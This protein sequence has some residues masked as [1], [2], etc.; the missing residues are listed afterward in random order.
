M[1]KYLIMMITAIAV[2]VSCGQENLLQENETVQQTPITFNLIANHP[3]ATKAVKTGWEAGDAIF[4]FFDNVAAPKHL[5]MAYDGSAWACAEYDG[6]TQIDGALGLTNGK[7]GTMRAVYLPF[8][9]DATVSASE[10]SFVFSPIYYA[11]Y[12]TATL[13]YTVTNGMVSGAFDMSIP[14]GYVQF[15][16]EDASATD[17]AY[18]LG[19][20]AVIPV[21]VA[22]IAADGTITETSDKS[23][24]DDMPGY[25]YSGGY[26]FS[27]KLNSDYHSYKMEGFQTS[28][29]ETVEANAYY[30]AKTKT[31]NSRSDYFVTGKTLSSHS[32]V[33][34]PAN[35]S[36]L[37]QNVGSGVTVEI[38]VIETHTYN[39]IVLNKWNTCNVGASIPEE[40][41]TLCTFSAANNQDGTPPTN[42]QI[43]EITNQCN[44]TWLT[45]HGHQ[46]VVVSSTINSGFIFLPAEYDKAGWYWSSSSGPSSTGEIFANL[47]YFNNEGYRNSASTSGLNTRHAVRVIMP[48]EP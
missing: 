1:K 30:F 14:E 44:W 36:D 17:G 28:T 11:Y 43:Q 15:F 5:K 27:G 9:S 26:L 8:G 2:L 24:V 41:G 40:L 10:N 47:L 32:A 4:V 42:V 38:G 21:G 45:L 31:D 13:D 37:W 25:A 12:L 46:G 16:I 29:A 48:Q 34:L 39:T 33:K 22:S 35:N 6:A 3:S 18:T 19:T 23:Y 7:K 20:D